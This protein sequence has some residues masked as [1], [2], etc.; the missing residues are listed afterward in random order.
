MKL[1]KP[2]A[3]LFLAFRYLNLQFYV[4][5]HAV[6]GIMLSPNTYCGTSP[7]ANG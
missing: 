1:M 7:H 6:P 2:D 5:S 4:M 3:A